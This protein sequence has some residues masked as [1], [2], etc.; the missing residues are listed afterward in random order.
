MPSFPFSGEVVLSP[1]LCCV[2]CPEPTS[3][4]GPSLAVGRSYCL[5]AA[6]APHEIWLTGRG[7]QATSLW[8]LVP[9]RSYQGTGVLLKTQVLRST[10]GTP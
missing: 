4:L 5:Q 6:P 8:S 9:G 1:S 2:C 3:R 10:A 7:A